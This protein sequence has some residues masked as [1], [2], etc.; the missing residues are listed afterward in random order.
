MLK[1]H[2]TV[3]VI[4]YLASLHVAVINIPDKRVAEP[5]IVAHAKVHGLI[6]AV[7]QIVANE[8]LPLIYPALKV[9]CPLFRNVLLRMALC[10]TYFSSCDFA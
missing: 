5:S 7:Y 8:K 4:A 10:S 3:V 6:A 1:G 9:C 2:L